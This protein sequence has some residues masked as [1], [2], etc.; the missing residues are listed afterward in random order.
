MKHWNTH[1]YMLQHRC[2]ML[3]HRHLALGAET[4]ALST[5]KSVPGVEFPA[6]LVIAVLV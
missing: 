1:R 2:L 6:I 3:Q 5:A 4:L